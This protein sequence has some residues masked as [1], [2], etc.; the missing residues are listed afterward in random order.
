MKERIDEGQSELSTHGAIQDEVD[1]VVRQSD[2]VDEVTKVQVDLFDEVLAQSTQKDHD[3]LWELGHQKQDDDDEEHSSGPVRISDPR[4]H[5]AA[6][7]GGPGGTAREGPPTESPMLGLRPTHGTDEKDTETCEKNTW[8]ETDQD[9]LDPEVE[10]GKE[11]V[12]RSVLFEVDRPQIDCRSVELLLADLNGDQ[13][14]QGHDAT[15]EVNKPDRQFRPVHVTPDHAT[16]S[17][18][19]P[20]GR[21]SKRG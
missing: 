16:R 2:D 17:P 18:T 7:A 15:D 6:T 19:Q 3:A 20:N 8:Y 5:R 4:G 12:D 14:R 13:V 21:I 10:T 9:R 1:P 11:L